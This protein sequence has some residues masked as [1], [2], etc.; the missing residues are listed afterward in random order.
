MQ[1]N[2]HDLPN[3]EAEWSNRFARYNRTAVDRETLWVILN[4][5][6]PL[7]ENDATLAHPYSETAKLV[8]RRAKLSRPTVYRYLEEACVD[9][10]SAEFVTIDNPHGSGV[11]IMLKPDHLRYFSDGTPRTPPKPRTS[12]RR[13]GATNV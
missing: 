6:T 2:Y 8:A 7:S 9:D 5:G 3:S 13:K 11:L 4:K 12:R 10:D 1:S